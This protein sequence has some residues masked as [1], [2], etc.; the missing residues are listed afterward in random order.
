MPKLREFSQ[1][2]VITPVNTHTCISRMNWQ[3]VEFA[4]TCI[5]TSKA[6]LTIDTREI[7][8][9]WV[10]SSSAAFTHRCVYL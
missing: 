6:L 9:K 3:E 8:R 2:H 5:H 10:G 1:V 7:T 4:D